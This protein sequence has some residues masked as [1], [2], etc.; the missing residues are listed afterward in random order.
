MPC[1]VE[2]DGTLSDADEAASAL[3]DVFRRLASELR[4]LA[5]PLE[6]EHDDSFDGLRKW[7]SCRTVGISDWLHPGKK[8]RVTGGAW[9]RGEVAT[10]L[11]Q[12]EVLIL[13][14][15]APVLAHARDVKL[16]PTQQ[17]GADATGALDGERWALEAY[18]GVDV[19]NNG[20]LDA[21]AVSLAASM[22]DRRFFA[23]RTEAWRWKSTDRFTGVGLFT[24]LT[25]TGPEGIR[26]FEFHHTSE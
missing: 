19:D 4:G 11:R 2:I 24:L 16:N 1:L 21:D 26:F 17:A 18:G 25:D 5:A 10:N 8:L 12:I 15:R 9:D 22:T 20:K 7:L 3:E 13:A 23:C 6:P 14:L